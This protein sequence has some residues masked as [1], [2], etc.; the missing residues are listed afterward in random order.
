MPFPSRTAAVFA[1]LAASGISLP[2]QTTAPGGGPW[3][4]GHL[5]GAP[6]GPPPTVSLPGAP[7]HQQTTS[8]S[9]T[10]LKISSRQLLYWSSSKAFVDGWVRT[11]PTTDAARL[12]RLRT[13]F[14][15]DDCEPE[16]RPVGDKGQNLVC[17]LPGDASD[18]VVIGA[19]YDHPGKGEGAIEN[20]SG[21][22][23]LPLLYHAMQATKRHSTYVFAAFDGKKGAQ[24]F[25]KKLSDDERA[26]VKVM[27]DLSDLGLSGTR[28]CSF[29]DNSV[30][31][32]QDLGL[33]QVLLAVARTQGVR[34]MPQRESC[35][36]MIKID[37]TDAF[38][39]AGVPVLIIHSITH[40]K[41]SLPGSE[42]DTAAAIDAASYYGSYQ[43]LATYLCLIDAN[44]RAVLTPGAFSPLLA[45]LNRP[46][47]VHA[48][49]PV[50]A[51]DMDQLLE[52]AMK[53]AASGEALAP[54]MVAVQGAALN[55]PLDEAFAKEL[56]PGLAPMN[57]IKLTASVERASVQP[58]GGTG[59]GKVRCK[60]EYT[61]FPD[62]APDPDRLDGPKARLIF[63]AS[64]F[65]AEGRQLES[66]SRQMELDLSPSDR[67]AIQSTGLPF[68]IEID[69][70]PAA[71]TLSLGV[72]APATHRIG[73]M[74]V[75][76]A[77]VMSGQ[78][79]P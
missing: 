48:T 4:G 46:R 27:L 65:S 51:P 21:A 6:I 2:G 5:G 14:V 60:V 9:G 59:N 11:V 68:E 13:I 43:L 54:H 39:K 15:K 28:S 30:R 71:A 72:Y 64:A 1:L 24:A 53:D 76:L 8:T 55:G 7:P 78:K 62:P 49:E 16:L 36:E 50:P 47:P 10:D 73:S 23:M 77:T 20:W 34:G 33:E 66:T 41:H 17:T 75:S 58:S 56:L 19:H 69:L 31:F 79:H 74:Q 25:F 45:A 32:T 63:A 29:P 22:A 37:D 38:R 52:P 12:D 26:H 70:S 42:Q 61:A 67:A 44:L 57:Q 40:E 3:P 35:Y 18:V